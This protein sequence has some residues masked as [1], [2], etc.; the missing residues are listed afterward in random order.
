MVVLSTW[1]AKCSR[2]SSATPAASRVRAS[3]MVIRMEE[4]VSRG[5]RWAL[6]ISMVSS[7]CPRPSSA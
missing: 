5:L 6:T 2:T 1:S 4:T 7:S 3:Y